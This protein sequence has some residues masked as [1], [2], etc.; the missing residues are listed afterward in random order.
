MKTELIDKGQLLSELII[1]L[2]KSDYVDK[3][4]SELKKYKNKAHLKGFRKGKTPLSAIKKMYGQS[5]LADVINEKLQAGLSA[6]ITDNEIDVLG[7]PLPSDRQKIIDFNVNELNDYE[8]IFD[9]GLAPD[10][11]VKGLS[12]SYECEEVVVKFDESMINEEIEN[13]QKRY[14]SQEK[15]DEKIEYTDIVAIEITES[16]PTEGREAF[17]TEVTIMP[18]RL[19]EDYHGKLIGQKL[20]FEFDLNVYKL[21]KDTKEYNVKKYFLKDA[22]EDITAEFKGIVATIKRLKPAELDQDFFNKAFGEGKV[23]TIDEA[24]EL[25][26]EELQEFYGTQ[27]KSITKRY[28]LENLL[29]L[30]EFDL[31]DEFLKRW[32]LS[33]NEKATAEDIENDYNGFVKNLK[34]T[35]IKQKVAKKEEIEVTSEDLK[36]SLRIKIERQFAQYGGYPGVNYD[37]MVNRLMQNQETVQ[38]E[39]EELLAEKVLDKGL[40]MVSLKT[41]NVSLDEYK[42][43]MKEL[44]ENIQ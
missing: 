9:L 1:V 34:W 31:P 43:I 33:T 22:P 19:T 44:Q 10:F 38:K 2:E 4:K 15:V 6:Y 42:E 18:D 13:L 8:F 41:K 27:G 37:D 26:R 35:L 23:T 28:I 3:Y 40:S 11:D 25:L 36:T 39:Y 29:E 17:V 21:E 20:G 7:N 32:L 24:R 12:S 30:N 5:V 16:K 14:G